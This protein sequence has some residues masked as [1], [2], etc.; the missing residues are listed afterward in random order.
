MRCHWQ[1]VGGYHIDTNLGVAGTWGDTAAGVAN[2]HS[3]GSQGSPAKCQNGPLVT[4]LPGR[5]R[6]FVP[7][8]QETSTE[9]L[10]FALWQSL[11][12]PYP[13]GW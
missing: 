4:L 5:A 7:P 9:S 12:K 2:H 10:A 1:R 3:L 8:S 11:G 6:S 13:G